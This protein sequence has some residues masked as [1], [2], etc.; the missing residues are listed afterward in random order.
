[1]GET[2]KR[3]TRENHLLLRD[4]RE[5]VLNE[6]G[7]ILGA[8]EDDELF[9]AH[10]LTCTNTPCCYASRS[11]I[12][13]SYNVSRAAMGARLSPMLRLHTRRTGSGVGFV[14]RCALLCSALPELP[15][16]VITGSLRT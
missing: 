6:A 10:T 11:Y 4:N 16:D 2:I 3:L 14:A 13:R 9:G 8:E 5:E 1:M 7:H 12:S 15:V